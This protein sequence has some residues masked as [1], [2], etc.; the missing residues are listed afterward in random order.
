[1]AGSFDDLLV[2]FGVRG[3]RW[4]S[5]KDPTGARAD[6]KWANKISPKESARIF[7]E[8][9]G[10][11]NK[12]LPAINAKYTDKS[13]QNPAT[14]AK[15]QK[16]LDAAFEKHV[17]AVAGKMT[18]PSGNRKLGTVTDPQTGWV[19]LTAVDITH[20]TIPGISYK[21]IRNADGFVVEYVLVEE[22]VVHTSES[23]DDML[24]HFGV[25]GMRWG[26]R[27]KSSSDGE[28]QAENKKKKSDGED[29]PKK[30]EGKKDDGPDASKTPAPKKPAEPEAPHAKKTTNKKQNPEDLSDAHLREA[31]NRLQMEKQYRELTAAPPGK[32]AAGKKF[33]AEAIRQVAMQ[34]A[35]KIGSSHAAKLTGGLMAGA[36]TAANPGTAKATMD[37]AKAV[38]EKSTK[39]SRKKANFLPPPAK[40]RVG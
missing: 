25:R 31:I 30:S 12:E 34:Q 20:A 17:N 14:A 26:V 23:F 7:S 3:M 32:L 19:M 39:T 13:L 22:G 38:V 40:S 10:R 5:R 15:Y 11:M 21:P 9:A 4:G 35:V 18:S 36:G 6:T 16:E 29:K 27:K 33:A 37:K 24:A 28:K 1:M 2:H 8:A